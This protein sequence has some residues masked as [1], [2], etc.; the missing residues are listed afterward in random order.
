LGSVLALSGCGGDKT[1]VKLTAEQQ[2]ET[3]ARIEPVGTVALASEVS[4]APAGGGSGAARSGE[5]VYNTKCMACHAT[6][7][8]GAPKIGAAAD[9]APRI[10]KGM[11]TL[12]A[13][14]VAGFKGMPPKGLCMDCSEA[15]V[16]A[17]VDYMVKKSK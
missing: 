12:Y 6:G 17:A 10:S 4:N 7:A 1:E 11:D 14:A 8:A 5:A 2:K 3:V 16:H 13:S 15:E 9:W